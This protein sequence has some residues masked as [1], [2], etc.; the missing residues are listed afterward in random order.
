MGNRESEQM[1]FVQLQYDNVKQENA[2]IDEQITT[3]N[4]QSKQY[5]NQMEV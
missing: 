2:R 4:Y 1:R 5:Q 3:I